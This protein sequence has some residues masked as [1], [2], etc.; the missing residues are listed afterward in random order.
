MAKGVREGGGDDDRYGS[1]DG[2]I[3]HHRYA[4]MTWMVTE[5]EKFKCLPLIVCIF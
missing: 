3:L 1:L 2:V 5:R 4:N